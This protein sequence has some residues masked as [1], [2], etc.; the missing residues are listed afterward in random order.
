MTAYIEAVH[1]ALKVLVQAR[2]SKDVV[3]A[4]LGTFYYAVREKAL[5][6]HTA[7]VVTAIC[8]VRFCERFCADGTEVVGWWLAKE[9]M[10][11]LQS[12]DFSGRAR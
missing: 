8:Q 10:V 6:T 3:F 1:L 9:L 11:R 5:A 12:S 7:D 2:I 4:T